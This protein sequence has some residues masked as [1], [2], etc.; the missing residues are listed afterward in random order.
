MPT[1]YE[2]LIQEYQRIV[3]EEKGKLPHHF[4]LL[5][6]CGG[7][8]EPKHSAFLSTL[9]SYKEEGCY[10]FLASFLAA[11]GFEGLA[12]DNP[13]L[14]YEIGNIDVLVKDEKKALI[15]ENKCNEAVDQASQLMRYIQAMQDEGFA[16]DKIFVLYLP[17]RA[18]KA[19][20][21]GSL[22]PEMRKTLEDNNQFQIKCYAVDILKWL[23]NSVLPNCRY[24][25][26]LMTAGV[27]QYIDHLQGKYHGRA[28]E[29]PMHQRLGIFVGEHLKFETL[30]VKEQLNK[31]EDV[32]KTLNN[33]DD[34]VAMKNFLNR[35]SVEVYQKMRPHFERHSQ[36][37]AKDLNLAFDAS[38]NIYYEKDGAYE[39]R[40]Y[41]RNKEDQTTS[42]YISYGFF[43]ESTF[44]NMF[45][46]F[47][48]DEKDKIE[49]CQNI[50]DLQLG[51]NKDWGVIWKVIWGNRATSK[52]MSWNK[53]A[54]YWEGVEAD[55]GGA[56]VAYIRD[57]LDFLK[58][59]IDEGNLF[60]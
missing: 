20:S 24:K 56:V 7:V 34:Q 14:N 53:V 13:I 36:Q 8:N 50:L 3:K 5:D 33:D 32:I 22:T 1:N 16:L 57:K 45:F 37:I 39:A 2:I 29:A 52:F 49:H 59:K 6:L 35:Y 27:E 4:N 12:F 48:T 42:Y 41:L 60:Y 44:D 43:V 58:K 28:F 25:D 38:E 47:S 11:M 55:D 54:D 10:P 9:L 26:N 46:M 21:E 40:F 23:R 15:V 31:L 30:E 17:G 19:P 18:E 51:N